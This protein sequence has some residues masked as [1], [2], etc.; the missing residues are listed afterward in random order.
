MMKLPVCPHCNTIY[1]Y[2]DVKNLIYK[3]GT[4]CYHCKKKFKVRKN[5]ILILFLI[6]ALITAIFNLFQLYMVE[7][8]SFIALMITNILFVTA[9]LF[10]IPFFISFEKMG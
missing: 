8:L 2:G 5:K 6:I 3:K 10:M 9:G 4:T 7:D 1:R